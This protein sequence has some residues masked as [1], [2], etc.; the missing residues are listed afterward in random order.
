VLHWEGPKEKL[1]E[2]F[3]PP[4][5]TGVP[6]NV[7]VPQGCVGVPQPAKSTAAHAKDRDSLNIRM[8]GIPGG[9]W[10]AFVRGEP[11]ESADI[12]CFQVPPASPIRAAAE[13]RERPCPRHGDGLVTAPQDRPG[14]QIRSVWMNLEPELPA[15]RL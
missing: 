11:A 2:M 10:G 12:T 15:P 4:L 5:P 1:S 8:R 14:P 7:N 6:L 13:V 9:T 3:S